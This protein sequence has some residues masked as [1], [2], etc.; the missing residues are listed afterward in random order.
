MAFLPGTEL[1]G[2]LD[3]TSGTGNPIM[4]FQG[5]VTPGSTGNTL[6]FIIADSGD[7][8]LDSTVFISGFGTAA[9]EGGTAGGGQAV[10][11]PAGAGLLGLG[12]AA[13]GWMRRRK[14]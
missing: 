13:L 10:P 2:I 12:L 7:A 9:P 1:D 11:A 5:L 8:Q 14:G 6:P 4:L 3:P